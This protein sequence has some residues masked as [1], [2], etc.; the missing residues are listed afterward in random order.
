MFHVF[1][2][3][4]GEWLGIFPSPEAYIGGWGTSTTMSLRVVCSRLVF[5]E[6]AS[7]NTRTSEAYCCKLAGR[8]WSL[9][10]SQ[11]SDTSPTGCNRRERKLNIFSNPRAFIEAGL[12][13]PELISIYVDVGMK[14]EIS[15]SPKAHIKGKNSEFFQVSETI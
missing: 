9:W 11:K 7:P 13:I 10:R 6:V 1:Q 15:P 8:I 4:G 12:R 3:G 2:F 5:G 14:I